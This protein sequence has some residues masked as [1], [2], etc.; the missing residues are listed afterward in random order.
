MNIDAIAHDAD[1]PRDGIT[2]P[3]Q[4]PH[5]REAVALAGLARA[6]DDHADYSDVDPPRPAVFPISTHDPRDASPEEAERFD[7][8]TGGFAE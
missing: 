6:M 3:G 2:R 4:P 1:L 8:F 7:E 5:P